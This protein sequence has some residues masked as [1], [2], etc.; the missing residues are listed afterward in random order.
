MMMMMM[1]MMM[2]GIGIVMMIIMIIIMERR[3]RRMVS[4]SED[5]DAALVYVDVAYG[6]CYYKQFLLHLHD[7]MTESSSCG[8]TQSVLTWQRG[9]GKNVAATA[10]DARD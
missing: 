3:R 1:M 4:S 5:V 2:T 7:K 6:C 8:I 9:G 10:D